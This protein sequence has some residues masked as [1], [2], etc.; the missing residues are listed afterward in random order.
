M[1][2][3]GRSRNFLSI[4]SALGDTSAPAPKK[5]THTIIRSSLGWI[6]GTLS[7]IPF[8]W[9]AWVYAIE[10]LDWH[11]N[12]W[13]I[14]LS[15][16][17]GKFLFPHNRY[18]NAIMELPA[19]LASWLNLS[20]LLKVRI[21][22]MTVVILIWIIF[23]IAWYFLARRGWALL[24]PLLYASQWDMFYF[25]MSESPIASSIFLLSALLLYEGIV[26]QS[27][28]KYMAALFVAALGLFFAHP[29]TGLFFLGTAVIMGASFLLERRWTELLKAGAAVLIISLLAYAKLSFFA[30]GHEQNKLTAGMHFLKY[31]LNPAL[32]SQLLGVLYYYAPNKLLY[33]LLV[34]FPIFT[35]LFRPPI[36]RNVIVWLVAIGVFYM[37]SVFISRTDGYG[38]PNLELYLY[39]EIGVLLF[40]GYVLLQEERR[41][42]LLVPQRIWFFMLVMLVGWMD[43]YQNRYRFQSKSR[44][45]E[46]LSH[47][48]PHSVDS[49]QRIYTFNGYWQLIYPYASDYTPYLYAFWAHKVFSAYSVQFS[50]GYGTFHSGGYIHWSIRGDTI[51][52]KNPRIRYASFGSYWHMDSLAPCSVTHLQGERDVHAVE[53]GKVHLQPDPQGYTLPARALY[54]VGEVRVIHSLDSKLASVPDLYNKR[55][56]TVGYRLYDEG[57][58]LVDEKTW[59]TWMEGDVATG[60]VMGI[61]IRRPRTLKKGW[62]EFGFVMVDGRFIPSGER[63]PFR[64]EW[65]LSDHLREWLVRHPFCRKL[66]A[67]RS[68]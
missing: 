21:Y 31:A 35:G 44:F 5:P 16:L 3:G 56:F 61:F 46:R 19:I 40:A 32:N 60:E 51:L 45:V 17:P 27:A 42:L 47:R 65:S 4:F 53:E 38:I 43:V 9:L 20:P 59:D 23:S 62:I 52:R 50:Q 10:R 15:I 1:L 34:F 8:L 25:A 37:F 55:G 24:I 26:D 41:A 33:L 39:G 57:H 29:Q 28:R 2:F 7:F 64:V 49:C 36:Y 66:T 48:L 22:S 54:T 11:D 14:E 68:K 30:S 18:T 13:M 6:V 58:K 67:T 12:S 63:V